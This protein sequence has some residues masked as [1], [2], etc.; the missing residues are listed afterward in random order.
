MLVDCSQGGAHRDLIQKYGV[1]GFPTVIFTDSKGEQVETLGGRDAA[2]V[3]AQI[4]RV[5]EKHSVQL[6]LDLPLAEA[7]KQAKEQSKL[8]G[9]AFVD[10]KDPK[11]EKENLYLT[12]LLMDDGSKELRERFVWVKRPLEEDGKKTD[13]AKAWGVS[14][15]PTV[16][17]VDPTVEAEEPKDAVVKKITS[18]KKLKKDL[19]K[20]L[21]DATK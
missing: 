17:V 20:A 3:K 1:Q 14:K 11:A 9:V 4:E 5:A 6:F 10:E 2:S 18:V 16:L 7:L 21:K 19:E 8:L 13:E 12:A 15:G